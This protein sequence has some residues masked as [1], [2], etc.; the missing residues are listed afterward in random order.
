MAPAQRQHLLFLAVWAVPK[1]A[2]AGARLATA[3][4]AMVGAVAGAAT[5]AAAAAVAVAGE[6]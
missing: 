3:M 4:V 2:A 6:R 5:R 1:R